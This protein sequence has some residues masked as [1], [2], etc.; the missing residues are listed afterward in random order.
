MSVTKPAWCWQVTR[1]F[2]VQREF[3]LKSAEN[4]WFPFHWK[5]T[6]DLPTSGIVKLT[7]DLC[8][9]E[10]ISAICNS[11]NWPVTC[12]ISADCEETP[13]S[14]VNIRQIEQ[15]TNN[16]CYAGRFDSEEKVLTN[17]LDCGRIVGTFFHLFIYG[18]LLGVHTYI[19]TVWG[20]LFFLLF[21]SI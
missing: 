9:V 19:H 14:S 13:H 3:F 11:R 10:S 15:L 2:S 5:Q 8:D 4:S 17:L 6:S 7:N 12:R 1:Q 18:K 20:I 16:L 21:R